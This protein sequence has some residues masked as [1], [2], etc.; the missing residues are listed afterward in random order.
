ML[1]QDT[2][3]FFHIDFGHF[4]DASKHKCGIKR[5]REPFI[6]SDELNFFLKKFQNIVPFDQKAPV[7]KEGEENPSKKEKSIE[8]MTLNASTD[9]K[10]QEHDFILEYKE[11]KNKEKEKEDSKRIERKFEHMAEKAF[12]IVRANADVFINLLVLMLVSGMEELSMDSID[13][14]KR[15]LFLDVTEEEA[16]LAFKS[17]I[18]KARKT[19][20]MRKFD[21]FAHG[22]NNKKKEK[23]QKKE[24]DAAKANEK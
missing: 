15:A 3:R 24:E 10:P 21:N 18:Q 12:L 1:Q 19:T 9:A 17:E 4:L 23:A 2:G 11:P 6:Y 13:F 20:T 5:D 7:K 8:K 22:Y 16:S 14:M